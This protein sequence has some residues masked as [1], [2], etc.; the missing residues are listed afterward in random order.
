MIRHFQSPVSHVHAAVLAVLSASVVWAADP[1]ENK[2]YD[3]HHDNVL[4]T[5][6]NLSVVATSQAA[7][8]RV[9][10]A[11]TG[12]IERL[13]LIL[14]SYDAKCELARFD[15]R[16]ANSE[17]VP[18]SDELLDVLT[19]YETWRKRSFN[20]YSGQLGDL[21]ALWRAAE[22]ND[23]LPTD[24]EIGALV[25]ALASPAFEVNA[26]DKTLR[27]LNDQHLNVD[28]LGK[29]YIIGKAMA[30]ATA[31]PAGI[32]GVLLSIGGD[33][34][35]WGS[36]VDAPHWTIGVQDPSTPALNAEPFTQLRLPSGTS[37]ASS[38]GY[39]RYYTIQGKRY[40]HILDAR[41]GKPVRNTGATVIA[42]DAAT[43]NALAT[44]C[45]ILD[46]A[47]GL[48]LVGSVPGAEC[49]VFG[50]DGKPTRSKGFEALEVESDAVVKSDAPASA[51][52]WPNGF[53]VSI[54]LETIKAR[55]RPY[56]FA[57]IV[58]AKG[59]HVK[60]LAAFGDE[61]KYLKEI[62]QWWKFAR[63]DRKLQSVT[64]ATQRASTYPLT[65]DGTDQAGE[66]VPAGAYTLWVEVASEDG[67]H[68]AKSIK[69][70]CGTAEVKTTLTATAAFKDVL[71]TYGPAAK[72]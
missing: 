11:I 72:D 19:Q 8:D 45:C 12:E 41:T 36:P 28:S 44:I 14:S 47:S 37:V 32:S 65:W 43:A 51:N 39:Q 22:R 34:R 59:D 64:H 4:G 46:S 63:N 16:A 9:D 13:R 23:R 42:S 25:K 52:A 71:I 31:D 2:A 21:I 61:T 7:A 29:G 49:I 38:G 68:A 55:H 67:P 17:P 62:R 48:R 1:V 56:V 20:A 27:K 54:N 10:K 40:S 33:I 26:K 60:T 5:T 15:A 18:A 35:V 3:F 24:Q 69:L 70:D 6:L 66:K 50:P 57:W 30:F 58:D 53:A